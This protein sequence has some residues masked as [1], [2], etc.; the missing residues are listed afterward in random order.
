M[1]ISAVYKLFIINTFGAVI[2]IVARSNEFQRNDDTLFVFA[3]QNNFAKL[4]ASRPCGRSTLA[5]ALLP[6]DKS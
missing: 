1:L 5:Q 3:Y 4:S 6:D 2:T